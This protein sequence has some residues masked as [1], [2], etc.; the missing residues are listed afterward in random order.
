MHVVIL[1]FLHE[2]DEIIIP[3]VMVG[4]SLD[5]FFLTFSSSSSS[6]RRLPAAASGQDSAQHG[7]GESW[8]R[9][10]GAGRVSR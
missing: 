2:T 5:F 9:L 8:R 1:L 10:D 3:D 6:V 7:D 4:F